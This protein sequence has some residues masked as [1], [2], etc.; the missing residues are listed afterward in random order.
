MSRRLSRRKLIVG[1]A[2]L[3]GTAAAGFLIPAHCSREK[4]L[5][6]DIRKGLI[7]AS[8]VLTMASH[9]L[10]LRDQPLA[11]EFA[12]TEITRNFPTWGTTEPEDETYLRLARDG[13]KD[14]RLPVVGLVDRPLSLS[15][16]QIRRLP[17]R[18]QITSHNCEMGWSAIGQWTGVPL[19]EVMK[20]AGARAE[21]RYVVFQCVDG[22]YDSL[23]MFD[24]VHPQTL[25]A[26]GLNG[27]DLPMKHGAPLRLRVERH[28]GYKSL[29]FLK[30]MHVVDSV[31][32]FGRGK[33]SMVAD[34][35]WHWY[36]GV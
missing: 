29:K 23:D 12:Y 36:A 24:V 33:G 21:A 16:E 2:A 15:M 14:W 4:F 34:D 30:S 17:S 22:W 20:L 35:D 27:R 10:L 7:G 28:C 1:A 31:K 8:D 13:F 6:P 18:T 11:P 5:P 19:L 26:Y 32:E 25:L 3:T 9:R